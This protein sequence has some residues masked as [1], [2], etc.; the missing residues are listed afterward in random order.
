MRIGLIPLDERPVNTRYPAM[1]ADIAGVQLVVPPCE[2]LSV[3]RT[4][5]P[6]TQ[7]ITWLHDMAQQLDALIVSFEMLGYGG[8]IASRIGHE[9][10]RVILE[11]IDTLR[12]IKQRCPELPILGFNVITRVSN[13]N[14]A[15]EEPTYWGTYGTRFY[16]LSQLL[17]RKEQ[18]Q[19]VQTTLQQLYD[20]FPPHQVRD[21]V[22]RR[23]RNHK[24]NLTALNLLSDQVLDLLVLSSDDTSPYGLPSHEKRWLVSW[25]NS[26]NIND[27]LLMYPGADEV[28]CA[29]LARLINANVQ[30]R[31]KIA[32][33]YAVPEGA[34]VIAAYEDVPIHTT[35]IRQMC[36]VGA[37]LAEED[38]ADSLMV[39][40]P[41]LPHREEWSA[42]HTEQDQQHRRPHLTAMAQSIQTYQ[43]H[44]KSVCVA[45]VAYPNGAD[46]IFF[47]ALRTTIA[48]P[49]L[50]A[51]GGWNT[52]GNTIGTVL[53]QG[54]AAQQAH[55]PAQHAAQQR[56]LLHRYIEDWGY[57][58]LV[59][60]QARA[61]IKEH[62]DFDEPTTT[63][64]EATT[65][66]IEQRLNML[67]DDL[68]GFV[69]AWCVKRVSLPWNRLFEIDFELESLS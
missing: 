64:M 25:A 37:V 27:R 22:Q 69:G 1:I 36:A 53:A 43:E 60:R 50:T 32:P 12:T 8:L 29:L 26:L 68:P 33:L 19:N 28:G 21:F 9:S 51:Y 7:L 52:A 6:C 67:V 56:F 4:P 46:P 14:V 55:T 31:P 44:Q 66:W 34:D 40:N 13:A 24:I 59:R 3:F 11:R 45:D 30:Y 42:V 65:E 2:L 20:E 47:E 39:I 63:T 35:V 61:R 58:H 17:D 54:C 62:T 48:L 23:L 18:G 49:A 57:Q 10:A 5:A 38:E 16:Q 15:I 41:P